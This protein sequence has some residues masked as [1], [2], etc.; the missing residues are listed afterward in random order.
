MIE[1]SGVEG[2][3][4]LHVWELDEHHQA[5]EA[6]VVVKRAEADHNHELIIRRELKRLLLER[7]SI[8]HCT[9]ELEYQGDPCETSTHDFS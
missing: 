4:H 5:L 7:Y 6:H 8:Q 2:V 1:V 3:H 9:L